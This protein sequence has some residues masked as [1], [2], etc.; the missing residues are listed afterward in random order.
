METPA[1][2]K[3]E[4]PRE[5]QLLDLASQARKHLRTALVVA[6]AEQRLRC[7]VGAGDYL[8]KQM[9]LWIEAMM[10]EFANPAGGRATSP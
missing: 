8:E 2:K 3:T 4:P 1:W 9:D 5:A 6:R 7:Y 10:K